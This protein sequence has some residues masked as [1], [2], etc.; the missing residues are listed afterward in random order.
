MNGGLLKELI[1]EKKE[2][3][4]ECAKF[5]E[6]KYELDEHYNNFD[7]ND[8]INLLCNLLIEKETKK[9][10]KKVPKDPD[11]PKRPLSSFLHFSNSY[12]EFVKKENPQAGI[13]E[14]SKMLGS[15]W[16]ELDSEDKLPYEQKAEEDKN[17]YKKEI[18][19]YVKGAN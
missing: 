5:F 1:K 8:D 17:R 6:H 9:H 16:N 7:I 18:E 12:R 11:A 2:I 15:I 13:G 14:I 10:N 4:K 3:I 19:L